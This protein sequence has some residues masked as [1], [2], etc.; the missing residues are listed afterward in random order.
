MKPY[1]TNPEKKMDWPSNDTLE[2]LLEA[3]ERLLFEEFLF[4]FRQGK[5]NDV[6]SRLF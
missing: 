5:A 3:L 6:S 2:T 1:L 4:F